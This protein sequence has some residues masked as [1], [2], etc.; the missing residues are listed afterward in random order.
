MKE[1]IE[2]IESLDGIKSKKELIKKLVSE[3]KITKEGRSVYTNGSL[4]F[5]FSESKKDSVNF[6][7]TVLSI[8]KLVSYD[9]KPFL[10]VLVTPSKNYIMLANTT[11]LNKVSHSSKLFTEENLTGSFNGGDI[12]KVYN[13]IPNIP[14]NFETLFELHKKNNLQDNIKMLAQ[15]TKEIS[16]KIEKFVPNETESQ[17]ILDSVKRTVEFMT[18]DNFRILRE[19]FENKVNTVKAKICNEAL[20]ENVNLRGRV[21]ETLVSG[22][23]SD[24]LFTSNDLNDYEIQI[25]KYKVGVDIKSKILTKESNPKGYN[26]DKF[27]RFLSEENTVYLTFLVGFDETQTKTA[28]FTPF[29]SEIIRTVEVQKHWSGKNSRGTIQYSGKTLSAMLTGNYESEISEENARLFLQVL[30]Q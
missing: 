9:T 30:I 18:S 24:S 7:N 26:V 15:K 1:I 29:D 13:G 17:N 20:N 19:S 21:V 3:L 5:R 12:L 8:K 16:G 27:L 25:G 14:N 4:Y 11:F 23:L 22:E 6:S 10:V 28:F 2:Y